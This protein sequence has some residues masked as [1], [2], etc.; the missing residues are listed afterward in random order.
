MS[1][2]YLIWP[3]VVN[4]RGSADVYLTQDPR[5]KQ[6]FQMPS[7]NVEIPCAEPKTA[8]SESMAR[9]AAE[10]PFE[11][12]ENE[13]LDEPA[14]E[15]R[16][17]EDPVMHGNADNNFPDNIDEESIDAESIG[18]DSIDAELG[19]EERWPVANQT[20]SSISNSK[21]GRVLGLDLW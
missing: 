17:G 12:P 3:L 4:G 21:A 16:V 8:K 6:P 14:A 9:P 5:T 19:F 2:L 10:N 1:S 7:K 20:R 11:D 15:R 18:A 13:T